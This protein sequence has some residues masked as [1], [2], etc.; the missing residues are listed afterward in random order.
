MSMEYEQ[1]KRLSFNQL[2]QLKHLMGA[3]LTSLSIW[4]FVLA[5][6]QLRATFLPAVILVGVLVIKP[7]VPQT[8]L[9]ALGVM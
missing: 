7:D 9:S 8:S 1:A 2:H 5:G 3:V 6:Y 4:A